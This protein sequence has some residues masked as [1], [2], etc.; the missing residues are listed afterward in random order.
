M[1]QTNTVETPVSI[2]GQEALGIV[3][4]MTGVIGE[5]AHVHENGLVEFCA[6]HGTE[7]IG[8]E[9]GL[10]LLDNPALSQAERVAYAEG[11]RDFFDYLVSK[12]IPAADIVLDAG[13]VYD[14]ED[15]LDDLDDEIEED[16]GLDEYGYDIVEVVTPAEPSLASAVIGSAIVVAFVGVLLYSVFA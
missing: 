4:L 9:L 5:V 15:D 7:A 1:E 10:T 16:D 3:K 11:A 12:T 13:M 8:T 6:E 14:G 2:T